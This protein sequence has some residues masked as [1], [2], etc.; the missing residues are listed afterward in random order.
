[1]PLVRFELPFD[2]VY[3][4]ASNGAL[5]T[6]TAALTITA[7]GSGGLYS[8]PFRTPLDMDRS[9][10]AH[11]YAALYKPGGALVPAGFVAIQV[12]RT[13]ARPDLAAADLPTTTFLEIPANHPNNTPIYFDLEDPLDPLFPPGILQP[14]DLVGL[15]VARLGTNPGDDWASTLGI[16]TMLWLEYSENCRGA[17]CC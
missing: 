17:F 2:R 8:T 9:R 3:A 4:A 1:M 15:R 14:D 5:G 10:E 6:A 11:L 13:I 12:V 7:A 16:V